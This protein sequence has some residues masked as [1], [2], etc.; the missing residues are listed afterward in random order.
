M[1]SGA[2]ALSMESRLH[3]IQS[4]SS[5]N[6]LRFAKGRD[7]K[8]WQSIEF[9]CQE[10]TKDA[11]HSCPEPVSRAFQLR[12]TVQYSGV[13]QLLSLPSVVGEMTYGLAGLP[14]LPSAT[15]YFFLFSSL[16]FPGSR[17]VMIGRMIFPRING[18]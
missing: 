6:C 15:P 4:P 3:S 17:G 14:C 13:V 2:G 8:Q 18:R 1:D 9:L 5:T 11:R 7:Q 12:G 10:K 16:F